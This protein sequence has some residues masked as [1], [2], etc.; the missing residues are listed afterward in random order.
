[1][2]LAVLSSC[3]VFAVS[4]LAQPADSHQLLNERIKKKKVEKGSMLPLTFSVLRQISHAQRWGR[5]GRDHPGLAFP[6]PGIV[7]G[8]HTPVCVL[9]CFLSHFK[10]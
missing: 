4:L 1:M 3:W 6:A 5:G 9:A 8:N 7:L 10:T 2:A